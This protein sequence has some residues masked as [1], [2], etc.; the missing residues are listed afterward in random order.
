MALAGNT[1]RLKSN[2][3]GLLI[4]KVFLKI[5]DESFEKI[6]LAKQ[7]D[8][9]N[10]DFL[11]NLAP[12]DL[13]QRLGSLLKESSRY[14]PSHPLSISRKLT[15]LKRQLELTLKFILL[16]SDQERPLFENTYLQNQITKLELVPLLNN[17]LLYTSPSPRDATLSR[18]PSSA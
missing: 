9:I 4:P 5:E 12:E 1:T 17:C 8:K 16:S 11:L 13:E 7:L 6:E 14:F 2:L 3:R 15:K 10:K 18:M